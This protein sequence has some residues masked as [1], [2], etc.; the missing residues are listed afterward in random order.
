[1]PLISGGGGGSAFNGG[2][3]THP[4]V[5]DDSANPGTTPL[6]VKG[7]TVEVTIDDGSERLTIS[8][9]G[10]NTADLVVSDT[11]SAGQAVLLRS[12]DSVRVTSDSAQVWGRTANA[13]RRIFRLADDVGILTSTTA[14]PNDAALN[15]GELAIYF[16]STNGASALKVKAKTTNGTVATATVPLT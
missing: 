11:A 15:A 3:I 2:T 5:I 8:G 16:D 7:A 13:L 14:A 10:G 4:L 6:D 9:L 1:M 12:P